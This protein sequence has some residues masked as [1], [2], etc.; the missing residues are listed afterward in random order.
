MVYDPDNP[1][2]LAVFVSVVRK[3]IPTRSIMQYFK[4]IEDN[5]G[6]KIELND[7]SKVD[8][9]VSHLVDPYNKNPFE[10][11]IK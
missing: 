6:D 8:Y 10:F 5:I 2:R 7:F 3:K 9:S 1:S 11:L 4:E